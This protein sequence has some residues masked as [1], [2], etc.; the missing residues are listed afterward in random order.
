M[1]IDPGRQLIIIV[2]DYCVSESK[3]GQRES[4]CNCRTSLNATNTLYNKRWF[5]VPVCSHCSACSPTRIRPTVPPRRVPVS[6]PPA[7]NAAAAKPYRCTNVLTSRSF[8]SRT[9]ST[10]SCSVAVWERFTLQFPFQV[11]L[12]PCTGRK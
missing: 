10:L 8:S 2:T 9:A 5:E 4:K 1:G 11:S 3:D 6:P 7:T 12:P